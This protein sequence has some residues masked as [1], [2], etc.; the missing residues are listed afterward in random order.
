M[1]KPLVTIIITTYRRPFLFKLALESA[2]NQTYTNTEIL[3]IDDNVTG[4]L[5]HNKTEKIVSEYKN[6]RYIKNGSNLGGALSRNVGIQNSNGEYIAFLDDDDIY[7]PTKI[8]AQYEEFTK[9]LNHTKKTGLVYTYCNAVDKQGNIISQYNND[10]EGSPVYEHMLECLAGT[11]L[12]FSSR[13]VLIDC[14]MFDDSPS[15]QD[16]ILLLKIIAKGYMV[17][18]V[19]EALV[20]YREHAGDGISGTKIS[21]IRGIIQYRKLCRTYYYLLPDPHQ[22]KDIEYKFSKQ[23]VSLYSLNNL[24]KDGFNEL[25][26]M[27]SLKALKPTTIVSFLKLIAPKSYRKYIRRNTK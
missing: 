4:S 11:S 7:L 13:Q 8:E 6:V 5:D 17:Y 15:K 18:R 26:N 10:L 16:S 1:K 21:N 22:Y 27:F 14:G 25:M 2:L 3:V 19:P 23:L 9:H 12:W 24:N 20:Q